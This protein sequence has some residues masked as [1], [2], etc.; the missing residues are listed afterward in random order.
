M[1]EETLVCTV[2]GHEYPASRRKEFDDQGLCPQ[3]FEEET[4]S[5]LLT[6][7]IGTI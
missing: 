1:K 5:S 7:V 3:C 6:P 4:V 2:C